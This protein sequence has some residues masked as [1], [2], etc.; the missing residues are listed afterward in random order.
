MLCNDCYSKSRLCTHRDWASGRR[1]CL[2]LAEYCDHWGS[3]DYCTTDWGLT[4]LC[5]RHRAR[6]T[7]AVAKI[8]A[9]LAGA[10]ALLFWA[11]FR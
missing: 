8:A 6:E 11:A 4:A 2:E 9:S 3:G 5:R 10:A 1:D 7:R